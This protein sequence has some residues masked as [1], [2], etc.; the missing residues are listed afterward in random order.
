[1]QLR[2]EVIATRKAV[3]DTINHHLA[4]NGHHE[5]VDHRTLKEQ[6]AGRPAERH[7]GPVKVRN[8]SAKEKAQYV[9]MRSN[10]AA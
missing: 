4:L 2:D 1:M 7:L 8:M 6:G 10:G 5:R 9:S 3:A